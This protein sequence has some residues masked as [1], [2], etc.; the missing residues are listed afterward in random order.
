MELVG[1]K[2]Q[3]QKDNGQKRSNLKKMIKLIYYLI[4][5]AIKLNLL[6]LPIL[7]TC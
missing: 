3:I 6:V 7:H 4:S 2:K 1:R 5:K